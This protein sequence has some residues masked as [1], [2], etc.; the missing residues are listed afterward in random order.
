MSESPDQ[1]VH[2]PIAAGRP[3]QPVAVTLPDGSRREFPA[4]LTGAELAAAIGPGLAEAAIAVKIDGKPRDLA[5]LIDHDA[6]VAII[7]PSTPEG[8][9]ILR[10]D[11]AHVMAE[12]DRKST[13]LNSSH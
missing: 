12:A 11:A 5:A 9:E 6:A 4:P 7:T 13:R 2:S 1:V 8:V 3:G 10:H